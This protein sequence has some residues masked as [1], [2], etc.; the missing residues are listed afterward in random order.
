MNLDVHTN[1]PIEHRQEAEKKQEFKHIGHGRKRKGHTLFAFDTEINE[2]YEVGLTVV[3]V[4]DVSKK[5]EV[6]NFRAVVN[7]KHPHL[8]A[9]NKTNAKRKFKTKFNLK[10]TEDD[11]RGN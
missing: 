8:Y 1:N 11:V 4:F 6:S 5:L 7:P 2:I 9:L 10:T 3:K